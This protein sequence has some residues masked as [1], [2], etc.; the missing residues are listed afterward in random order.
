MDYE[1]LTTLMTWLL[2]PRGSTGNSEQMGKLTGSY[3]KSLS[4]LFPGLVKSSGS[5]LANKSALNTLHSSFQII[6]P[7]SQT[8]FGLHYAGSLALWLQVGS[9]HWQKMEKQDKR[10]VGALLPFPTTLL[11]PCCSP[12]SFPVY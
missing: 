7:T 11:P 4:M 5:P 1:L 8:F 3:P 12:I 9:G 6:L 10:E 2:N